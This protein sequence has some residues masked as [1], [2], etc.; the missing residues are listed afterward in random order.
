MKELISQ[1]ELIKVFQDTKQLSNTIYSSYTDQLKKD[2]KVYTNIPPYKPL[3]SHCTVT[4]QKGGTIEVSNQYCDTYKLAALNFADGIVPG[5]LVE[6]GALTQ[7]ENICRC[8]NLYQ[9][10]TLDEC[11]MNYYQGNRKNYNDGQCTDTIIYS[12][13]VLVFKEDKNYTPITPKQY[14]IITCPAPSNV[15]SKKEEAMEVYVQRIRQIIFSAIQNNV[16]CLVLGAWGC[17]AFNQ[18]KHLISLA[19]TSVLND[20]SGYFKKVIFAIKETPTLNDSTYD[21]FLHTFQ[22]TYKGEIT[23]E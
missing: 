21:T 12:P 19:F 10:I 2:T 4:F 15:F 22:N 14:D 20:Y 7:E 1:H 23:H 8:S 17:G 16:E 11:L 6:Q 13:N 5:G 9:S 3:S 18:D